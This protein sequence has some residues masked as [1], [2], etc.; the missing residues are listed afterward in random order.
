[1]CGHFLNLLCG[2]AQCGSNPELLWNHG[3]P[4]SYE[5]VALLMPSLPYMLWCFLLL[6]WL[7]VL[8]DL[9]SWFPGVLSCGTCLMVYPCWELAC[10]RV[11]WLLVLYEILLFCHGGFPL[12][13][14]A[15]FPLLLN[16]LSNE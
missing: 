2:G 11:I 8:F 9:L 16:Q 13:Q 5:L 1:M 14:G 7:V 15:R 12:A 3:N 10:L 4:P 6:S